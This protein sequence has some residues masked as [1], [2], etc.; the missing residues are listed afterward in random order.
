MHENLYRNLPGHPNWEGSFYEQLTEYG[1]W[2]RD[3]FWKLHLDFISIALALNTSSSIDRHLALC[4]VTLNQK[5]NNLIAAHFNRNDVF[6]IT[7]INQEEILKFTE[8]LE[9]AVISVFSGD[10]LP[11]SAFDLT[12]PLIKNS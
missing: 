8:R 5:I 7:N 12:N 4:V 6:K 1:L 9:H 3:E 10:I 2:E 11:E